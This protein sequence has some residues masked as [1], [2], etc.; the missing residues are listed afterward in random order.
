MSESPWLW[1]GAAQL[2]GG[3]FSPETGA[4]PL[5]MRQFKVTRALPCFAPEFGCLPEDQC[6]G[7]VCHAPKSASGRLGST[8]VLPSSECLREWGEV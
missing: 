2:H 6:T 3:A 8:I 7:R 1:I 4:Q 5:W